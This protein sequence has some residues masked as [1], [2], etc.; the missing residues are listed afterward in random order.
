MWASGIECTSDSKRLLVSVAGVSTRHSS[1]V[2]FRWV[3][4][5][6]FTGFC[7]FVALSHPLF[8][9]PWF[10]FSSPAMTPD[11]N[12]FY[13]RLSCVTPF[14]L[15]FSLRPMAANHG[16]IGETASPTTRASV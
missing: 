2:R 6:Q 16:P 4:V 15:P 11:G 1:V 7:G 8:M 14:T 13:V 10:P 12:A 3:S 5:S 9:C